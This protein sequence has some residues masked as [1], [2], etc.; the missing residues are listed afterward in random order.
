MVKVEMK[1]A[2]GTKL[3]VNNQENIAVGGELQKTMVIKKARRNNDS[4]ASAKPASKIPRL[5]IFP[6]MSVVNE[7]ALG[8]SSKLLPLDVENI[9]ENDVNNVLL[10]PEYVNDIYEYLRYL[11]SKQTVK[12]NFLVIQKEMTARMRSVLIDWIINVHYQFRLLPETLYLGISIMDRFFQKES[13]NKNKI[14][15]VGVTAFFIASKFE[16]IYPPDIKDFVVICDQLY[17]KR[18]ILKMEMVILKALKFELGRPLPL[19]FLRRNSKAAHADSRIHTMAKYLMELTLVE[20]ECAHWKPSLL[21]AVALYVTL[22]MIGDGYTWTPTLEYYS[23]YSEKQLIPYAAQ[24]CKVILKSEKSKFQTCRK[25]Y[26][27]AKLLEISKSPELNCSYVK[28]MAKT[29]SS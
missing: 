27:S 8:F 9:D 23:N 16:E 28:E 6:R 25:K 13:V 7:P 1:P 20:Y 21:A 18:D 2:I 22:R 5:S 17:H 15:L 26:S 3:N 11:E 4:E 10:T 19:H 24:L 14:Q 29:A 12:Q